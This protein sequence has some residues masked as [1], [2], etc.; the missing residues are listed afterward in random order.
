MEDVED[1][2]GE[3]QRPGEARHAR[4]ERLGR[5]VH[6]HRAA[7][8]GPRRDALAPQVATGTRLDAAISA[9]FLA[10]LFWPQGPL[11][12][13]AVIVRDD[14]VLAA[15]CFLP[16]SEQVDLPRELGTRH[17]AAIGL[18]EQT[19]ALV[20]VVSE[21]TGTIALADRGRL[22]RYLDAQD[23]AAGL[24]LAGVR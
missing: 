14:R 6:C 17:R 3:H 10:S 23:L 22:V 24:S 16:L 15:G 20:V 2:V 12:D 4:R 13:G 18:S 8:R 21:A 19:D 9:E 1:A 11:H 7:E 5:E